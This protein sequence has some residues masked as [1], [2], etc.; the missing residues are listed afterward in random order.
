MKCIQADRKERSA[1]DTAKIKYRG[2]V[3]GFFRI[4]GK[5]KFAQGEN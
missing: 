4:K 2:D 3:R 5:D 1:K